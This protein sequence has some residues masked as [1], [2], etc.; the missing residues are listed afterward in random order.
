MRL[1][2]ARMTQEKEARGVCSAPTLAA[3]HRLFGSL[4]QHANA[5]ETGAGAGAG[6]EER[7]SELGFAVDDPWLLSRC[8]GGGVQVGFGQGAAGVAGGGLS[9]PCCTGLLQYCHSTS[10]VSS[11]IH[12][13]ASTLSFNVHFQLAFSPPCFNTVFQRLASAL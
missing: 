1:I 6:R 7:R 3:W 8:A 10:T 11:F 2:Q 4:V 13:P 12:R 5:V 9:A